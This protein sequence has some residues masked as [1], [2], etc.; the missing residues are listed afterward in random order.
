MALPNVTHLQ[1]L[2]LDLVRDDA[3]S[4]RFLRERLAEEGAK[5]SAP[6]FYQLMARLE[7][8]RLISGWYESFVV[9][10]QTIKE[11]KYEITPKGTRTIEFVK[12]FYDARFRKTA[13]STSKKISLEPKA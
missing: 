7:D 12:E 6:A 1:F 2:V 8:G 10:G 4:G 13:K 3:H 11:R 5:K 9:N